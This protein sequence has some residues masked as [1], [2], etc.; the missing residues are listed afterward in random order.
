MVPSRFLFVGALGGGRESV[1]G[2]YLSVLRLVGVT[3]EE[4]LVRG[5]DKLTIHGQNGVIVVYPSR[6]Y[7]DVRLLLQK[8]DLIGKL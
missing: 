6:E 4:K 7:G 5:G 2:F 8:I 3:C 1:L